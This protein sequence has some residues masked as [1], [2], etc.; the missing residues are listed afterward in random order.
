MKKYLLGILLTTLFANNLFAADQ[1]VNTN[2]AFNG[3]YAGIN[4]GYLHA[5][6]KGNETY[7]DPPAA[8]DPAFAF[9]SLKPKGALYSLSVGYNHKLNSNVLVGLEGEFGGTNADDRTF[10]TYSVDDGVDDDCSGKCYGVSSA[11]KMNYS[12]RPKLGMLFNQE[13]TLLYVTGG[14]EGAKIKR[15]FSWDST[16]DVDANGNEDRSS[17]SKN[18]WQTGWSLGAGV[19]HLI[20]NQVTARIEYKHSDL[21]SKDIDAT[22]VYSTNFAISG[23]DQ[24]INRMD[25]KDDS[26]RLGVIYHY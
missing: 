20:A 6:D 11:V 14:L 2:S 17:I 1:N 24:H 19:E 9:Q 4:L 18:N 7:Y 22:S 13:K 8:P 16:A 5:K 26:L 15:S 25:Y 21:G 10:Q 23:G 12:L 3:A